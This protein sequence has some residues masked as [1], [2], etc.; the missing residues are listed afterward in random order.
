MTNS[1]KNIQGVPKLTTNTLEM[2]KISQNKIKAT[3]F[4]EK[5]LFI[6][7]DKSLYK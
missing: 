3:F 7:Y 4:P 6:R 2:G 5:D 1:L